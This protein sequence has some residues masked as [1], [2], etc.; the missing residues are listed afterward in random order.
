MPYPLTVWR[1][2]TVLVLVLG[3][4]LLPLA[5]GRWSLGRTEAGG[6]IVAYA[7]Y[8]AVVM[9]LAGRV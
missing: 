5:L 3:F 9:A 2:D 6:L 7:V 8:L 4:A 1:I